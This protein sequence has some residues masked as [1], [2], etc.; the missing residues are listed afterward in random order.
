ML[1]SN[2]VLIKVRLSYQRHCR[3]TVQN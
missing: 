1:V 3:S 2:N